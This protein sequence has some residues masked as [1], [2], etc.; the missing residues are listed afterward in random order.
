[1]YCHTNRQSGYQGVGLQLHS[2]IYSSGERK[3]CFYIYVGVNLHNMQFYTLSKF[4]RMNKS[5]VVYFTYRE[6]NSIENLLTLH[7]FFITSRECYYLLK[8]GGK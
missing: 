8:A 4:W 2:V 3:V 6:N 5:N 7:T 1:M